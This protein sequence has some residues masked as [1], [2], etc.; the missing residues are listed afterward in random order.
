[1]R[2]RCPEIMPYFAESFIECC[3]LQGKV[4]RKVLIFLMVKASQMV[5]TECTDI[6]NT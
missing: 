3:G 5:S 2:W 6:I 4:R 1:M